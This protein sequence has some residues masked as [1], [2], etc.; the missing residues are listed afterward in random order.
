MQLRGADRFGASIGMPGQCNILKAQ[1]VCEGSNILDQG[2]E[3][4][5]SRRLLRLPKTAPRKRD[6][7]VRRYECRRKVD[8]NMRRA[9]EAGEEDQWRSLAAPIQV[10]QARSV[11][12]NETAC[13]SGALRES[14]RRDEN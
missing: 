7:A 10:F 13:R 9:A 3:F 6:R 5:P 8:E 2:V 11:D 1:A 14:Q 12:G 4:V